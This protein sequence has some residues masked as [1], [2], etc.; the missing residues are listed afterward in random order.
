[1]AV[2]SCQCSSGCL[3]SPSEFNHGR[4]I[5]EDAGVV[6][7]RAVDQGRTP[8]KLFSVAAMN[9]AEDVELRPDPEE[10]GGEV[11]ASP[12]LGQDVVFIESSIGS[13]IG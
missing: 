3:R 7:H 12:V 8:G 5:G 9:V 2:Y 13:F 4:R 11:L 1:M 10:S 6:D